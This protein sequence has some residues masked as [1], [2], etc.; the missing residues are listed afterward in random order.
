[1]PT[2]AVH[3]RLADVNPDFDITTQTSPDE[4]LQAG[5]ERIFTGRSPDYAI[6]VLDITDPAHPRY[7]GLRASETYLPGS[8]GKILVMGGLFAA[9]AAHYPNADDRLR[10]LRDTM[11]T[12]DRF[13]LTDGH[14]V[15]IADLVEPRLLHRPIELGDRFSLYEWI[16]HAVSPSSN[17]AGSTS[18]KQAMMLRHFGHAYPPSPEVEQVFFADTPKNELQA[19]ALDTLEAPLREA[20]LKV[21]DLRQGTMFTRGASQVVPGSR[22][23]ASPRELVRWLVRLEQGRLIDGWSSLEMKRLLYF[24]RRRYRYAASPALERAA[25]YFKS[26]SFYQCKPEPGFQCRQYGGNV[27]NIMN[28][29][30]IIE[31]PAAPGP[32]E[33]QRVYL[34]AMMSNVLRKNSAADHRDIATEIDA[35]IAGLH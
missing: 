5:L 27:T 32:E 13:V 1:M 21:D 12:A 8:V 15:P 10:L 9:L 33:T 30:A 14:A 2:A 34:V 11:V 28:S 25:V 7:A 20:D 29:V 24:T 22:S 17:A 16:D 4:A 26:G 6:A 31:N 19:L 3:L 23:R 35:L 18:W